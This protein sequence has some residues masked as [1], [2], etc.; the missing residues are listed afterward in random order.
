DEK[1]S[2]FSFQGAAP[3][4]FTSMRRHF[5]RRHREARRAF[6]DVPLNFSFRSSPAILK[7]VDKTF[8][9]ETAWRGVTA[10]GEPAPVQEAIHRQ[11][12]GV[13]E[14]W[15][16]VVSTPASEGK[17]WRMPLDEPSR[18]EP[19]VTLARRIAKV[20]RD[21]VAPDSRERLIDKNDGSLRQ[22]RE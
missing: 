10:S 16:P 1:Q 11:M 17:D 5:E 18:D 13:V 14:L 2:I 6:A 19:A 7:A 3:E 4:Q 12:E 9:N 22:I 15:P 8:Q 21:W 20:I